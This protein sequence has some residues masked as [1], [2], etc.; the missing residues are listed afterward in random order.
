MGVL[1]GDAKIPLF[2]QTNKQVAC[3]ELTDVN[4]NL[5]E[6]VHL[7]KAKGMFFNLVIIQNSQLPVVTDVLQS[8]LYSILPSSIISP[9]QI[10]IFDYLTAI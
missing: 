10:H 5:R 6:P 8:I 3:T 9:T 4:T 1:A 2:K 7:S